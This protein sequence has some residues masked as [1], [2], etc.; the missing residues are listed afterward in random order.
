MQDIATSLS[1]KIL[2]QI[3][4]HQSVLAPVG[5]YSCAWYI[6]FLF[7]TTSFLDSAGFGLPSISLICAW[8]NSPVQQIT[9]HNVMPSLQRLWSKASHSFPSFIPN[10][11]LSVESPMKLCVGNHTY[12]PAVSV[13]LHTDPV[14][15]KLLLEPIELLAFKWYI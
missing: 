7:C 14:I 2:H 12:H 9:F 10:K 8:G 1:H 11:I 3:N 6:R 5:H 15:F 13:L 4:T